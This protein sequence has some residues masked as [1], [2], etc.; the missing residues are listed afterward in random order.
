MQQYFLQQLDQPDPNERLAALEA[1][2][3]RDDASSFL[4]EAAVR[5]LADPARGVREHAARV[6]LTLAGPRAAAAVAPLIAHADIGV[7]NLAGEVLAQLG[8]PAVDAL[9][10]YVDHAD[11]DVRK[12][13]IDVLAQ[14]PAERL[15]PYIALRLADADPNVVLAAVDALGA[16]RA[17]AYGPDL[18]ALYGRMPLARPNVVAALGAMAG[19]RNLAFLEDALDD[20]DPV[21][22]LAAAEALSGYDTV[23]VLEALLRKAETV[24]PMAQP[25]VLAA[26]VRLQEQHRET[27]PALPPRLRPAFAAMLDDTDATYRRA[28]V[29]GLRST[30]AAGGD[31]SSSDDDDSVAALLAGHAGQDDTVDV[32]IFEALAELPGAFNHLLQAATDGRLAVPTAVDFALGLVA[33][34]AVPEE[35][36]S[37]VTR[38]VRA[39]FRLLDTDTRL[40]ALNVAHRLA[41]PALNELLRDGL[42]D[43]DPAVRTFAQEAAR[44]LGLHFEAPVRHL[45]TTVR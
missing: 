42:D 10:P 25:V 9:A 31:G 36:F 19:E 4:L 6:L 32:A 3:A 22:Q 17:A 13:A 24:H 35:E 21:V 43:L 34:R 2:S 29:R 28:A 18:R 26:I 20:E 30:H 1:L 7:R 5:L 39:H 40:A 41:H 12:F 38:F 16:L 15:A 44:H 14:L 8:K 37:D 27:V 33:R 11:K 23:H 45:S